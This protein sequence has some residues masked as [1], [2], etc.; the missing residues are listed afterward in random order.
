MKNE[1]IYGYFSKTPPFPGYTFSYHLAGVENKGH[2][3]TVVIGFGYHGVAA[4]IIYY[5]C[6]MV[7]LPAGCLAA[8]FAVI[9]RILCTFVDV[10]GFKWEFLQAA[11][12]GAERFFVFLFHK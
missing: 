4:C 5:L 7:T 8:F 12:A 11:S 3:E 1:L 9:I 10:E 6:M 2:T